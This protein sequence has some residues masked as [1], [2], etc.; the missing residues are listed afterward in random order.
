MVV[1]REMPTPGWTFDVDSVEADAEAS[2][3]TVKLTEIGPTGMV[4]QVLTKTKAEI[5][6]GVVEPGT[7]FVEIWT[8]RG[9]SGA[10]APGHALIVI[11]R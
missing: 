7:Y 8:R 4:A 11:A 1:E 3:L 9:A 10:H 6:L 2:R 5:P